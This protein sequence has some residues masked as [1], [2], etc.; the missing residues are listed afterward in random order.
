VFGSRFQSEHDIVGVNPQ[1]DEQV[2]W[3]GR[4]SNR[5]FFGG[6][7]NVGKRHGSAEVS[8]FGSMAL[9][10]TDIEALVPVDPTNPQTVFEVQDF[11]VLGLDTINAFRL[12]YGGEKFSSGGQLSGLVSFTGNP[13]DQL[14]ADIAGM[15]GAYATFRPMGERGLSIDLQASV[16]GEYSGS[17]LAGAA[18]DIASD[19]RVG[20]GGRF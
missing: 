4:R 14:T 17:Q 9:T 15:V 11:N 18:T 20:V 1:S 5:Q 19:L 8:Y 6:A 7:I 16:G 10:W 3:V 2:T 12:G 13:T